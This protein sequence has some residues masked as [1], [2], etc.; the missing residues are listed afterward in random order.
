MNKENF[1][2]EIIG[3]RQIVH[4]LQKSIK[5]DKLSHAYLFIGPEGIGKTKTA[6]YFAASLF[7]QETP[8]FSFSSSSRHDVMP[9]TRGEEEKA[10]GF[11]PCKKCVFCQQVFKKIHPDLIWIKKEEGKKNISIEQIR[12]LR[13]RLSRE[14]FLSFYKV[15][16][17]EEAETLN[18]DGWNA[19]LKTLEEPSR[20]TIIILIASNFK[21][22]PATIISRCQAIKFLL[23]SR[24]EIYNYFI[25]NL[26]FSDKKAEILS[27]LSRGRPG[28][29]VKFIK[30][31][32]LLEK[33]E[34]ETKSF[35][36]IIGKDKLKDRFNFLDT[37]VKPKTDFLEARESFQNL[38]SI[39]ILALRDC[40]L[41]KTSNSE[42]IV[43]NF[44]KKDLDSLA[45][46]YS[47]PE[48]KSLMR[49]FIQTKNYLYYNINPRLAVENLIIKF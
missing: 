1:K 3:H 38:L 40:L 32:N 35:F 16:I 23:V 14:A 4:F 18:K 43:N 39:W 29:A 11:I 24:R 5:S 34:I 30:D 19:L 48:I 26:N 12:N 2:W 42:F 31:E 15:A 28:L 44:V 46:N 21:N 36:D 8:S 41:I 7:C 47:L 13:E 10:R 49:E 20:K 45:S 22:L 9:A 17:I 37:I 6:E 33:Y 27:H 25:K